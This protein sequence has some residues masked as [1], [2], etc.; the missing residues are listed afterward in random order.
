MDEKCCSEHLFEFMSSDEY[1]NGYLLCAH[2][3]VRYLGHEI[4]KYSISAAETAKYV[5]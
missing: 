5:S 1:L 3:G 4:Y 2:L